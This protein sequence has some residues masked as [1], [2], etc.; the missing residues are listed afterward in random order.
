MV[1]KR[2]RR[3]A[4]NQPGMTL[5]TATSPA[6]PR[7]SLSAPWRDRAGR[8]SL[9]KAIIFAGLFIPALWIMLQGSL[10]WLGAKPVTEALHQCGLWAVRFLGFSLAVTPLRF[11]G[12]WPKLFLVRRMLGLAALGYVVAHL[13]LYLVQ[14]AY[15]VPHV[16]WEIVLRFYLTIGAIAV[17]GLIALGATSTDAMVRRLGET[18]N[19]L[20]RLVYVIAALAL[21]HF[22]IQTKIDVYEAVLT[23][24]LFGLAMIYRLMRRFRIAYTPWSLTG[25]AILTGFLTMAIEAS[26]Y[27]L[28]TGVPGL[29]VLK[30]N[31]SF[32]I[33]IRPGWWVMLAGLCV[34]ALKI[35]RPSPP[36]RA[37]A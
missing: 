31:L 28:A 12:N 27:A 6:R 36:A 25:A 20:H 2:L 8:L 15:D 32:D 23:T 22:F 26:W 21:L 33:A 34:A 3:L 17:V 30:A 5:T 7:L 19:R 35:A 1:L 9:L 29:A 18:W 13:A 10:G 16:L 4:C 24:G 11:I 14:E 37:R